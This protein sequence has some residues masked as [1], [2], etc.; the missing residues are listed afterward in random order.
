MHNNEKPFDILIY[1][2]NNNKKTIA[3]S[4]IKRASYRRANPRQSHERAVLMLWI[5]L[6]R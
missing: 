1:N 3:Y 4:A 6:Y 2:C 5:T